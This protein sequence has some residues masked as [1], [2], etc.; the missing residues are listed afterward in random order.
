MRTQST[1]TA[2]VAIG[3]CLAA[4]LLLLA[5]QAVAQSSDWVQPGTGLMEALE[6]GLVRIGA[7]I[8][9][10]GVIGVGLWACSTG[11]L[12]WSRLGYVVIGGFLIMAGPAMVRAL[13]ETAT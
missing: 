2:A 6:S 11:R 3:V 7:V 9:G 8:I 13:L 10:I 5:P 12:E 1:N 4:A